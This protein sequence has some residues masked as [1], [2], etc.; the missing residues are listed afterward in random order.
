MSRTKELFTW[1]SDGCFGIKGT[2]LQAIGCIEMVA[3]HTFSTDETITDKSVGPDEDYSK[4]SH[5]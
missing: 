5:Q 4:T 3:R 1:S 2:M